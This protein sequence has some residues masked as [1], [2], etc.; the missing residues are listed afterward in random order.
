MKTAEIIYDEYF[1]HSQVNGYGEIKLNAEALRSEV[2]DCMKE[3]SQ[4]FEGGRIV[5]QHPDLLDALKSLVKA[6]EFTEIGY[7]MP[8]SLEKA[9][10]AIKN[11][12]SIQVEQH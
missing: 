11:A 3:Y 6:I 5:E 4:Q 2:L 8:E 12:E 7:K 10:T 9:K 1:D